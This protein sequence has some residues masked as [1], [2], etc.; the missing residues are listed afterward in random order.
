MSGLLVGGTFDENGGKSSY[1]VAQL[2]QFLNATCING[3]NLSELDHIDL[4]PYSWLM[5]MPNID[6]AIP[7]HLP[8][9]LKKYPHLHLVQ[10]KR[11]IERHYTNEQIVDRLHQSGAELA[12]IIRKDMHSVYQF[13]VLTKKSEICYEGPYLEDSANALL[14][15]INAS[16]VNTLTDFSEAARGGR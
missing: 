9:I 11:A 8:H 6:N 7:K 1:F 10:S 4:S 16:F 15:G 2:A 3:G 14:A 13:T 12:L 5:W